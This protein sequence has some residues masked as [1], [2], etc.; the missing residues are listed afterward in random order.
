MS[1][2]VASKFRST[3]T[4]VW[5]SKV[6]K[7]LLSVS[8]IMAGGILLVLGTSTQ[9]ARTCLDTSSR[10][11]SAMSSAASVKK[12]K[13]KEARDIPAVDHSNCECGLWRGRKLSHGL[14]LVHSS[15]RV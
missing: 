10:N 8:L 6:A 5:E 11:C 7:T 14:L 2:G 1:S 4:E 9:S 3:S 13:A 15:K 12:E